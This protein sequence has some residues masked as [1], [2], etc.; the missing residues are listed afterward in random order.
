MIYFYEVKRHMEINVIG[1]LAKCHAL[2][3]ILPEFLLESWA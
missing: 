3:P 1:I 2:R